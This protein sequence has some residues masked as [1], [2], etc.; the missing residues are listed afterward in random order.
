[1]FRACF[2]FRD[3]DLPPSAAPH[4]YL[5]FAGGSALTSSRFW[6]I[7]STVWGSTGSGR[8]SPPGSSR[9]SH[10]RQLQRQQRK[11]L[12]PGSAERA[13]RA[14][15]ALR[16][17][18]RV[19]RACSDRPSLHRRKVGGGVQSGTFRMNRGS[20][21]KHVRRKRLR[22]RDQTRGKAGRVQKCESYRR[23]S[24]NGPCAMQPPR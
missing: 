11:P 15:P 13:L 18:E 5:P 7:S 23:C 9:R 3:S 4:L 12:S 16:G 6:R 1:M 22:W 21:A 14:K 2:G 10:G 17:R 20:A 8:R 24:K 19:S